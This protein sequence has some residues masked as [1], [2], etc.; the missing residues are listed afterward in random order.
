MEQ[1]IEVVDDFKLSESLVKD[2]TDNGW[3][4]REAWE[5]NI[6][7]EYDDAYTEGWLFKQRHPW[8]VAKIYFGGGRGSPTNW[9]V[10]VYGRQFIQRVE[11]FIRKIAPKYNA[12]ATIELASIEGVRWYPIRD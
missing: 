8:V 6:E 10:V 11:E 3:S 1:K 4:V 12:N 2:A 5:Y 7:L 9:H